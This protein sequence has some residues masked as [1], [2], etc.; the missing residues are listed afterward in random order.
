V[1]GGRKA[2]SREQRYTYLFNK[3]LLKNEITC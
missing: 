1:V 2:E 3:S